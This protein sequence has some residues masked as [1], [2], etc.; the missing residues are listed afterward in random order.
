MRMKKVIALITA[1]TIVLSISACGGKT[2]APEVEPQAP[3][4]Q[5]TG[6]K[7]D[8]PP[9]DQPDGALTP[10]PPTEASNGAKTAPPDA[11]GAEFKAEA[12]AKL[13]VWES[14]GAGTYPE[15]F[16]K[17]FTDKYGVEVTWEVIDSV[18]QTDRLAQKGAS[19][20]DVMMLP[21]TE[22]GKAVEAGLVLPNDL[23]EVEARRMNAKNI[24]EG[25]SYQGIVYGYPFAADTYLLYYNKNLIQAAPRTFDDVIDFSKKF[26]NKTTNTYGIMW[27]VGNLYFS[28]PFLASSGGYIYG[29]GGTDITDMGLNSAEAQRSMKVFSR[30]REVLPLQ[31]DK[32]T[33]D[34]KRERFTA[35]QLAMDISGPEMLS[36][37][38]KALGDQLGVAPL[39]VVAGYPAVSFADIKAWYVN[40]DSKY[41]NAAKLFAYYASSREAQLNYSVQ[42]GAIPT[43]I[44]VQQSEHILSDPYMSAFI[45][46][47]GNA[48]AVPNLPEMDLVWRPVDAALADIW[49]N[50]K[51][52]KAA[53]DHAVKEIQAQK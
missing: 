6:A 49:D 3:V 52:A 12:D 39:P 23:F 53:L 42:T 16:I 50:Q 46:Q 9:V 29:K 11:N 25:V 36:D 1:F 19:A 15:E 31:S 20:A 17:A 28:Y 44:E 45:A 40:A 26:T 5:P 32:L 41:P 48:Q 21:S 47:L 2:A 43:N 27:D 4:D 10:P 24:V 8:P 7:T 14:K 38:K 35:G 30:L 22:L 33:K 18:E 34:F 13:V 37:Y 51:D